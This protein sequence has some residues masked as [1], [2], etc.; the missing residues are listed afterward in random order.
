[1]ELGDIVAFNNSAMPV[2]AFATAW[3]S[4]K[5]TIT[6]LSRSVGKLNIELLEL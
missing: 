1:M 2:N 5:F 3:T 6:S 4:L